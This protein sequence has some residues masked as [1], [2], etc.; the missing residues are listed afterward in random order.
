MST[1]SFLTIVFYENI[2]KKI[3]RT[4]LLEHEQLFY[5]KQIK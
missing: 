3:D 4:K 1:A 2:L 5:V